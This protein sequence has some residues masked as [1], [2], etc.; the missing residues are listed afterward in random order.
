MQIVGRSYNTCSI[1]DTGQTS[2]KKKKSTEIA[3]HRFSFDKTTVWW[4]AILSPWINHLP[5]SE[6][7]NMDVLH[8]LE[9]QL[10]LPD[11]IHISVIH[12]WSILTAY[13]LEHDAVKALTQHPSTETSALLYFSLYGWNFFNFRHLTCQ[14]MRILT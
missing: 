1:T 5:M 14:E 11:F 12:R 4:R 8:E 10:T 6:D 9:D 13:C 3:L 7:C 2:R